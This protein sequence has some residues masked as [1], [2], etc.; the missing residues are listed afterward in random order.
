M[1]PGTAGVEQMFHIYWQSKTEQTKTTEDKRLENAE[2]PA[3]HEICTHHY[4]DKCKF[5]S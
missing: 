5:H 1:Y 2:N 3:T 4:N